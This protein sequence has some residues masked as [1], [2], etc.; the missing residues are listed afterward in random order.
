MLPAPA[1]LDFTQELTVTVDATP[2]GVRSALYL[3]T[4]MAP[5]TELDDMLQPVVELVLAEVLNNITEHAYEGKGGSAQVTLIH[6]PPGLFC[7]IED[8]GLSMPGLMAPDGSLPPLDGE[9]GPSEG[10]YG[11][12]LI[13]SL[14]EDFSYQRHGGAN[15]LTFRISPKQSF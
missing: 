9:G 5:V 2:E 3:L 13:R 12:Y 6:E 4:S 10:G 7:R 1:A 15:C 11:W 8:G 14:A